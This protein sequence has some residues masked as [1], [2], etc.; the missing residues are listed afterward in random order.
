MRPPLKQDHFGSIPVQESLLMTLFFLAGAFFCSRGLLSP[1][2]ISSPR[3]F[4]CLLLAAILL[5]SSSSFGW[6]LLPL[7]LFLY[8][9]F[10]ERSAI[11]WIRR[12]SLG[13]PPDL[14][15]LASDMLLVPA[16]LVLGSLGF[17]VASS[18]H[19]VLV[20]STVTKRELCFRSLCM[21][22]L[23]GLLCFALICL[24]Y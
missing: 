4:L 22:L 7:C 13:S 5:F 12:L 16:F 10:T 14:L 2:E 23:L 3:L 19:D 6:L 20:F 9:L 8:G 17:S 1:P 15:S 24:F 21:L 11:L 18:L